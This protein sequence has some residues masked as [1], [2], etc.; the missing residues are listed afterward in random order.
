MSFFKQVTWKQNPEGKEGVERAGGPSPG[1]SMWKAVR[2]ERTW[3]D[4]HSQIM[5]TASSLWQRICILSSLQWELGSLK[6]N[7]IYIFWRSF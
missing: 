5:N 1:D 2:Q 6:H 4:V 3:N 7:M